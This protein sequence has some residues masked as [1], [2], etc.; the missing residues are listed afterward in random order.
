MIK[1]PFK[2]FYRLTVDDLSEENLYIVN[3]NIS[4]C[5][6]AKGPCAIESAVI[7]QNS[8]IPKMQC[9]FTHGFNI[10]GT[11]WLS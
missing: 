1:C 3:M 4:V 8:L 9:N 6:E 10:Q 2:I 5:F 11:L 7:L